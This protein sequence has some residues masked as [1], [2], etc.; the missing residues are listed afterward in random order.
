MHIFAGMLL[1]DEIIMK[2]QF[3]MR[4]LRMVIDVR[5][6]NVDVPRQRLQTRKTDL[7]LPMIG[8]RNPYDRRSAAVCMELAP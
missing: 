5:P 1:A 2:L 4:C 7:S 8:I 6:V 3:V